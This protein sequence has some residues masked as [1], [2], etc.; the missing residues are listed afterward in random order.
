MNLAGESINAKNA[1][2]TG[3]NGCCRY[4]NKE[5]VR[6]V[7]IR[8]VQAFLLSADTILNW[9]R[10]CKKDKWKYNCT[11]KKSGRPKI[12]HDTEMLIVEIASRE[13]C[14]YSRIVGE[15][16]KL[17]HIVCANTVK[18]VLK[19]HG[20]NRHPKGMTW[21]T[22]IKNHSPHIWA[23]DFFTEELITPFGLMTCY[24]LFFIHH[25]TRQVIFGGV[26]YSPDD[27]WM[28]Q[29]AR[30]FLMLLED[31][32]D[33]HCKYFIHDND[34]R[35]KAF[36]Q[37]IKSENIKPVNTSPYTP[38]MNSIAERFVLEVRYTLNQ[39]IHFGRGH[40]RKTLR[41]IQMHHNNFRPHQ[42]IDNN[43]PVGYQASD[44][45]LSFQKITRKEWLAAFITA[46]RELCTMFHLRS[47]HQ[48]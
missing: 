14:G 48:G 36:K 16:K 45:P 28:K 43:V 44:A 39:I 30:N 22:F 23:A 42:G 9:H 10:Q 27:E 31:M 1:K 12:S 15:L 25:Q 34:P 7:H 3:K 47:W 40:L 8:S 2:R 32:K 38:V 18:N 46:V 26:T 13:K 29:Q 41:E 35:W 37:I 19:K 11:P 21:A 20:L 33:S 6:A 24:V 5:R 17:G 4:Q